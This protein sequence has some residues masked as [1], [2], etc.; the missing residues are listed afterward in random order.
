MAKNDARHQRRERQQHHQ[1][2]AGENNGISGGSSES[3]EEN[4]INQRKS[5]NRRRNGVVESGG[6][7]QMYI[8]INRNDSIIKEEIEAKKINKSGIGKRGIMKENEII[9]ISKTQRNNRASAKARTSKI[10]NN[11]KKAK[12]RNENNR[13]AKRIS[14]E[15]WHQR[16]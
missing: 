5:R 16:R 2:G 14:I 10:S 8:E 9:E 13:K 4:D 11:R 15:S 12:K 1:H 7:R 3:S 6:I